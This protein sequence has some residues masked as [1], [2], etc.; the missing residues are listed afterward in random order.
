[1]KYRKFKNPN[2]HPAHIIYSWTDFDKLETIS[3]YGRI[4]EYKYNDL[5]QLEKV[6][7][8]NGEEINYTYDEMQRLASIGQDQKFE[9]EYAYSYAEGGMGE[10][11][12]EST[13]DYEVGDYNHSSKHVFDGLGRVIYQL[14]NGYKES[15]TNYDGFGRVKSS[16]SANNTFMSSYLYQAGPSSDL[17]DSWVE[18]WPKGMEHAIDVD[19][20]NNHIIK[21]TKD[22]NGNI[23]REYTN[24]FGRLK[25]TEQIVNGV[26]A[27]VKYEYDA[28]GNLEDVETPDGKHYIYEY[29]GLNQLISKTIPLEGTYEYTYYA[30]GNM[31]T[32]TTPAGE[33][34]EYFYNNYGELI[35]TKINNQDAI[36]L[37]IGTSGINTGKLISKIV[38]LLGSNDI[39]HYQYNYDQFGRLAGETITHPWGTD[40]IGIQ[41]DSADKIKKLTRAGNL[42]SSAYNFEDI[43]D[44]DIFGRQKFHKQKVGTSSVER[45][46]SGT[47]YNDI[48]QLT[49]MRLGGTLNSPLQNISYAYNMRDWLRKINNDCGE[50]NIPEEIDPDNYDGGLVVINNFK[51]FFNLADL[52]NN[53]PTILM[54]Q[55]RTQYYYNNQ[56]VYQTRDSIE[57]NYRGGSGNR[58]FTHNVTIVIQGYGTPQTI[59]PALLTQLYTIHPSLG[60]PSSVSPGNPLYHLFLSAIMALHYVPYCPTEGANLFAQQIEYISPHG[61]MINGKS[62]YTGNINQ[63]KS[64]IFGREGKET[65]AFAYDEL[66]RLTEMYYPESANND[67]DD[68]NVDI[69]YADLVGNIGSIQR[70]GLIDID[71]ITGEKTFGLMDDLS[72]TYSSG[73]LTNVLESAEPDFGFKGAGGGFSYEYGR[74]TAGPGITLIEYNE[75]GLPSYVETAS[76]DELTIRYDA[77]GKKWFQ[78]KAWGVD[79]PEMYEDVQGMETKVYVNGIEAVNGVVEVMYMEHGRVILAGGEL[80][81]YEYFLKDHL[82]NNRVLFT[83]KDGNGKI[84]NTPTSEEVLEVYSYYPFGMLMEGMDDL[85][86]LEDVYQPYKYN[87]KESLSANIY[88]YGARIYMPGIG[89]WNA[90]DPLADL[91]PEL[92]PFRYGFNNPILFIDPDGLFETRKEARKFRREHNI[93]GSVRKNS[94]GSYDIRFKNSDGY[95]TQNA[96]GNLD[97]AAKPSEQSFEGS[98]QSLGAYAIPIAISQ[99]DSP[100]PGPADLVALFVAAGIATSQFIVE[101]KTPRGNHRD[102]GLRDLSDADIAKELSELVGRLSKEQNARKQRLTKEQ[103]VR[104]TRNRQKKGSEKN[105]GTG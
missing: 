25:K 59:A 38:R 92:T 66:S 53:V 68:F 11:K 102:D 49:G 45:F 76:G 34:F 62:E 32:Q 83:D 24:F 27:V 105:T 18:G 77:E 103:K 36:G 78:D 3:N 89:R 12:V 42:L 97:Y 22:E 67:E 70:N 7:S 9:T 43:F 73:L 47:Q 26:P 87:G 51:L 31:E 41:Y 23:S 82:G 1:M 84:D 48:D 15:V 64:C 104:G 21:E 28:A 35:Y 100:A 98:T 91:A 10:N 46:I 39:I 37:T 29:D 96:N 93:K 13:T 17:T 75:L 50:C 88:D 5:Y 40:A 8:P 58:T 65:F 74:M 2:E 94:K 95:V 55:N 101:S 86:P 80:E 16:K 72:F 63:I 44:Y 71:D 33:V 81:R 56:L 20:V 57:F 54:I 69:S 30:S 19:L 60:S 99:L 6:I 79:M 61:D 90:V 85:P 4:S 52:Q 14:E